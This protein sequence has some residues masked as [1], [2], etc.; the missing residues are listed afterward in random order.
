VLIARAALIAKLCIPRVHAALFAASAI[1][2]SSRST[3]H[4]A[5]KLGQNGCVLVP[6]VVHTILFYG[7]FVIGVGG[8]ICVGI[9]GVASKKKK[10]E[11]L[12]EAVLAARRPRNGVL[13]QLLGGFALIGG[14]AASIW[15]WFHSNHVVFVM[16]DAGNPA[17]P[18]IRRQVWI[19]GP[20]PAQHSLDDHPGRR[21]TWIVNE[22][23]RELSA[24]SIGYGDSH[25][26]QPT[27]IPPGASLPVHSV[28]YIGPN[29][30]PPDAI[31][32]KQSRDVANA[33]IPASAQRVWLTWQ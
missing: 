26:W 23:S 22:S 5:A 1:R 25:T 24:Q 4:E 6:P 16:N 27:L 31:T 7:G 29:D 20:Y 32:V 13:W 21:V 28:D 30:P 3:S 33:G 12:P 8:L 11:P 2:W 14:P 15:L 10:Q 9:G 19:G 18:Q 17:T